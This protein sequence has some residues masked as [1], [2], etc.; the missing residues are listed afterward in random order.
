MKL[1]I[2]GLASAAAFSIFLA[3]GAASA[4]ELMPNFADV[5]TGWVT[6]RYNPD[7]F[8]DVG[9]FAGR[10]DV[11]GIGIG[12]NGAQ[13][14]RSSSY[15][16]KFYDTQGMQHP[17]SGGVGDSISADLYVDRAW[18]D[19]ANGAVRTD[20][21]GINGDGTKV[22]DYPII[23][24]TNSGDNGYVG[25]QLWDDNLN[26]GNGGWYELSA[27]YNIDG[28]NSLSIRLDAM[29]FVYSLNGIDVYTQ[30]NSFGATTFDGVIIQGYNFDDLV[31]FPN[32]VAT[33]YTAHWSNAQTAS[34]PEPA[35]LALLGTGL[36]GVFAARRRRKA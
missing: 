19:P 32:A 30:A 31:N 15:S 33:P 9:T 21:W 26:A 12:P 3:M 34:A 7:S 22:V 16:N 13:A 8:S 4:T 17:V 2:A 29:G 5:P 18:L 35:T 36:A 11:L 28:W 27:N 24:F 6:D 20:L 10:S 25:F 23:G 14:N 1:H